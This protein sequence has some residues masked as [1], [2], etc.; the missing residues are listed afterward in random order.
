MTKKDYQLLADC[1]AKAHAT[2]VTC[3]QEAWSQKGG[4]G[5]LNILE[6]LLAAA[7]K[8]ENPQFDGDRFKAACDAWK[9]NTDD[10]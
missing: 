8:E 10:S 3:Y 6:H 2:V 5:S 9:D 1:I 7:L 4:Q